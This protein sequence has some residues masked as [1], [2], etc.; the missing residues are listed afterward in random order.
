[1]F[2]SVLIGMGIDSLSMSTSRILRVKQFLKH[3]NY[4]EVKKISSDIFK[5]ND[6]V[7]IKKLLESYYTKINKKDKNTKMDDY[8]VK[9][10]SLADWGR[11]EIKIAETE[12]PGL[13]QLREEYTSQ[14]PLK[15]ARIAGC[16]HMTIQTAVLIE[17]LIDLGA[18]EME[19]M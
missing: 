1:M 2:T 12:M 18:S 14:K 15:G 3:I 16:L 4:S 6:N 8:K 5:Q 19:F 9:D 7:L 11:K 13:M 10:I 17:T